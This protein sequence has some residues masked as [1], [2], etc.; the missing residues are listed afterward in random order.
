M[1]SPPASSKTC[2]QRTQPDTP[3]D[4]RG[5]DVQAH[6]N[7]EIRRCGILQEVQELPQRVGVGEEDFSSFCIEKDILI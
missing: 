6:P 3:A 7:A 2:R 1:R 5:F 4:R